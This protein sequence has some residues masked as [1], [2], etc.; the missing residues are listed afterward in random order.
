MTDETTN[1][2]PAN[3]NINIGIEQI[4]AAILTSLNSVEVQLDAL[5][6]DYSSKVI[7]VNQDQDTKAITFSIV[8]APVA[9]AEDTAEEVE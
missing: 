1:A 9:P 6:A 3:N 7:A 8:D 5:L 4:C 2:T